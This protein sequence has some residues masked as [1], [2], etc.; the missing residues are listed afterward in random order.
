[1]ITR[2]TKLSA[3]FSLALLGTG[4]SY[5]PTFGFPVEQGNIEAGRQAFIDHRCHQC[6]SVAGV[7]LPE[8]AGASSPLFELGGET[9]TLKAYSELVTSIINPDHRISE[10]YREEVLRQ[11]G[12]PLASPMPMAHIET[13]T[14]RQL[15]DLVAFLDSRYVLIDDYET[16]F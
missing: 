5:N 3:A 11:A 10:R 16:G 9:S 13:M 2:L 14:V 12:P 7:R 1:V 4:C 15:I 8:L 6:H